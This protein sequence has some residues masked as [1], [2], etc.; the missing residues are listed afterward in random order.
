MGYLWHP[1][2]GVEAGID[3]MIEFRNPTSGEMNC[4]VLLVQSKSRQG[5]FKAET[6]ESCEFTCD[7]ADIN[8]WLEG[9]APIILVVSRRGANEGYWASVKDR[10]SDPVARESR[11]I[12]FDKAKDRFDKNS[13]LALLKLAAPKEKGIYHAPVRKKERIISNFLK[14]DF[15]SNE[16]FSAP[17]QYATMK[18][19]N[20]EFENLGHRKRNDFIIKDGR[21]FTFSE[22]FDDPL[23]EL[24]NWNEIESYDICE[25]SQSEDSDQYRHFVELLNGTLR[26]A[27]SKYI[28]F[29]Y[30]RKYFFFRASPDLS[31]YTFDYEGL[32]RKT[33]QTVFVPKI[34][35]RKDEITIVKKG[36][37]SKKMKAAVHTPEVEYCKHHAFWGQFERY[38]DN[39]FFEI[40]PTYHYTASNGHSPY[41][42]RTLLLSGIKKLDRNLAVLGQTVLWSRLLQMNGCINKPDVDLLAFEP[43]FKHFT[44]GELEFFDQSV[45]ID[46]S[47]WKNFLD[48]EEDI[49]ATGSQ[50]LDA[51]YDEGEVQAST[52]VENTELVKD[53]SNT[54]SKRG[55]KKK[56]LRNAQN[57]ASRQVDTHDVISEDAVIQLELN[58]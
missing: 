51:D 16:I 19:F 14:V 2:G 26:E 41:H 25:Y 40:I 7:Q 29:N 32:N 34:K 31:P 39:W 50:N 35:D 6:E 12:K 23:G 22:L 52:L 58:I 38:D 49:S 4:L 56:S 42:N 55:A 11:T 54:K 36:G 53:Q 1:T 21:L 48:K 17:T 28:S 33:R 30:Y 15:T 9:N 8:Y 43:R 47:R 24:C 57:G 3:G 5:K 37:Q 45:G 46:D 20:R 18:E 13:G 44:F 10:F 27:L